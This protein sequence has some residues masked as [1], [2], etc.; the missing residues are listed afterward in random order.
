MLLVKLQSRSSLS[1]IDIAQTLQGTWGRM[2]TP[3]ALIRKVRYMLAMGSYYRNIERVLGT[4]SYLLL[5][6]DF[7]E[8]R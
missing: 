6:N 5:G 8:S 1:E 2:Y 3:E 7:G 4:G